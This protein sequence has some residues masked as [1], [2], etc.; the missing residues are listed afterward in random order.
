MQVVSAMEAVGVA[1]LIT[2][3]SADPGNPKVLPCCFLLHLL[4]CSSNACTD[5]PQC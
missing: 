1:E 2:K 5:S 4:Q 3:Y